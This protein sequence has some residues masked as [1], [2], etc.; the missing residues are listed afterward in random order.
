MEGL[1]SLMA[2]PGI[3]LIYTLGLGLGRSWVGW[4]FAAAAV[5]FAVVLQV[6]FFVKL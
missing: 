5:L 2:W 3:A 1:G 6:V 4:P